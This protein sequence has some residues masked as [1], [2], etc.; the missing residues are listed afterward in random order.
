MK[1]ALITGI[2]GMDGSFLAELLL[3]KEYE[4]HGIIRRSSSFNTGRIDHIF[5]KLYLHYGDLTDSTNLVSI[6]SKVQPDLVFHLA[7]QS[8]VKVSF[9]LPEYTGNV[10]ALGTLRLL[11]AIRS[12][13]LQHKTKFYN[14]TTSELFGGVYK[15]AQNEETPFNPR[16]PYAIAKLYSFW[17][18]K[19]YREAYGMFIC[20]G[21]L[22]N[23]ESNRR[24][25]TFVTRKITRHIGKKRDEILY[26][27]NLA[28]MR[29]WGSAKD[30]VYGMWLML[31]YH[32]PEDF[33][34]ATGKQYSVRQ[35][36]EKAYSCVGIQISWRGEGVDEEG[37]DADGKVRVKV[38]PKYFRPTE[39]EN[40]LGDASKAKRLLGWEPKITFDELVSEMVIADSK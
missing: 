4:V 25:E 18:A 31:N 2:N 40:L 39:V 8:H 12:C 11:E 9:E 24:G 21:I 17:I 3:E 33:V 14:A 6:I 23:H 16:S 38:D 36:V 1:R 19:N 13:G 34:L 7:A 15:E 5:S 30:Y 20:N 27:G 37:V 10:D 32:I 26:L 28:A 35:F 22:F 29:D